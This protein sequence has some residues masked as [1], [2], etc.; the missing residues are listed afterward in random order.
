MRGARAIA[1]TESWDRTQY[2][3]AQ[4]E[5]LT[6]LVRHARDRS[7][8]YREL[9][10]GLPDDPALLALPPVDKPTLMARFD[11]WV[12]DPRIR[13]A[14]VREYLDSG[15]Y[16]PYLGRFRVLSTGGSSRIP[17]IFVYDR[18][19]WSM[20]MATYLYGLARAGIR[21]KLPADGSPR[22]RRRP[23]H[24]KAPCSVATAR[25]D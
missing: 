5:A 23:G 15:T 4:R 9:Y 18:D 25:S 7:P 2:A 24:T 1:S 22:S 21:P 17:G 8:F 16:E 12:T 14:G 20:I 3:H 11:E 6:Q 19:G 13:L 10:A